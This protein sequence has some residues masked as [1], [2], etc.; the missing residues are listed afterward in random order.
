MMGNIKI[1]MTG[2]KMWEHGVPDSRLIVIERA[3]D[4]INPTTG[5][6]SARWL[7]E[8]SCSEHNRI[9]VIG[10]SLRNGNTKSCGCFH[11]ITAAQNGKET[12]KLNVYDLSGEYGIGW[13]SN[14]NKEF[15]FDLEDYDKIKDYC[16][17]EHIL[18]SGYSALETR[19]P[20]AKTNTRMQWLI[21][22]KG[23]DH[24][25][26]NPLNNRKNNL[27]EATAAD[28]AHNAS[29][30]KDNTSGFIGVSWSKSQCLWMSYININHKRINLGKFIAL[31][32]AIVARLKAELK[33]FGPEFAPQRH[34]FHEYKI[35]KERE[36]VD[37]DIN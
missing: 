24:K 7:C 31:Y 16:W 18:S 30:R 12:Q 1:D 2:W 13:T 14:T 35:T 27:R 29:K 33:Y 10:T 28:N 5:V 11:K 6:R 32:D 19:I 37:R 25:D 4:Y 26:R 21:V 20:G 17:G 3:E 15:Y 9:V 23:Y 22:G 34:L 8:C 36:E